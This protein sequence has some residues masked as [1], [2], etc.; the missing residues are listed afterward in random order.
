MKRK[1]YEPVLLTLIVVCEMLANNTVNVAS[2]E[3]KYIMV[4]TLGIVNFNNM[5]YNPLNIN[6]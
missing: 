1:I 4:F 5:A 6:H 2:T 3:K